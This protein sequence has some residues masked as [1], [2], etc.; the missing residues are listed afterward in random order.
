MIAN[1]IALFIENLPSA[2]F[3]LALL[4]ASFTR[5]IPQRAERYLSWILLSVGAEGLW[6]GTTARVF[7]GDGSKVHQLA[8]EPIP[9]R[10]RNRGYR[11]RRYGNRILLKADR[12]QDGRRYLQHRVFCRAGYRPYS[13]SHGDRQHVAGQFRTAV[14][15]HDH[16]TAAAR[17]STDNRREISRSIEASVTSMSFAVRDLRSRTYQRRGVP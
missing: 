10:D 17:G 14:A 7:P 5:T 3:I 13:S 16:Q 15:A 4:A 1:A 8:G 11:S 9:V 6:A 2:F 12:L